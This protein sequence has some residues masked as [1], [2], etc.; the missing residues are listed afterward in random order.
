[1]QEKM[2]TVKETSAHIG[3]NINIANSKFLRAI[4]TNAML[5]IERREIEEVE[6]FIYLGSIV[7]QQ[8]ITETEKK[9]Y[10]RKA[11]IAFLQHG[12]I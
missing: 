7:D 9:T 10:N 6:S 12:N 2:N 1:M 3:L 11:K 8:R 4:T 5:N